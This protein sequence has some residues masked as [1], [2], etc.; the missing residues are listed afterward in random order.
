MV[1][2]G[3]SISEVC[4]FESRHQILDGHFCCTNFLCLFLKGRK[5]TKKRPGLAH[6]YKK[7]N[8]NVSMDFCILKCCFGTV[9]VETV[10]PDTCSFSMQ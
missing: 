5:Y 9:S 10:C 4:G 3:D 2:G 6:F 8:E 7:R 1:I